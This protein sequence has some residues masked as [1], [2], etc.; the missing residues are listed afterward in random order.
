MNTISTDQFRAM[1]QTALTLVREK[2][3]YLSQLDAVTG[4]GDH[5]TAIVAALNAAITASE[6]ATDLH[7]MFNDIGFGIM[8][9]TS[10]STSTLLGGFFLGMADG[11]AGAEAD[12]GQ[13]KSMFRLGL[14][15][16]AKNTRATVGDKTMMDALMPA[17]EA[18][19]GSESEDIAEI[20]AAGAKAARAGAE[21][22]IAMKANF[23]RAR[24]YGERSIG[25]MDAGAS[26]W[27]TIF[28]AFASAAV[29]STK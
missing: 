17:V 10:G 28:E 20:L 5:G 21:A 6:A 1:L 23:G 4:D 12:A 8:L 2:E 22:T 7:A 25:T 29:Q 24:N 27:A 3:S 19:A 26:S 14:A 13:L 9:T 16:V 15:G 18:I 11:I